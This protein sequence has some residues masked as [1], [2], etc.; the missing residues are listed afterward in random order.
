MQNL[1]QNGCSVWVANATKLALTPTAIALGKF[2]GIHLGHKQV[3]QPVLKLSKIMG[4]EEQNSHSTERIYSTVVTFNP[5]PREFFSGQ[6]HDLLT[7]LDEKVEQLRSLGVEQLVLLPFDKE[8][9][10]LTPTEFVEKILIKQLQVVQIS[11]GQDFR[12]GSRRLGTAEDL[13]AIAAK[14]GIQV[15]I[16]PLQ[17]HTDGECLPI[18]TTLIREHLLQGDIQRANQLLGRAYTLIGNVIEGEKLGRTI[19]FP[20]ANLELPADKFLPRQG[21]YAVSVSPENEKSKVLK[22]NSWGVMNIGIRPTVSG[23][24]VSVEVHLLDWSGDLYGEKLVVKLEKFL[25]PEQKFDSLE[26]LKNQIHHDC[27]IARNFFQQEC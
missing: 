25:R 8:L 11:V 21:V 15:N 7:P 3:L 19:G 23:N 13:K 26:A 12:F 27:D 24:Q 14:Y 16:V 1:S 17:I 4:E 20:T 9:S 10:A 2:D 5:H 18:S 6:P 22:S